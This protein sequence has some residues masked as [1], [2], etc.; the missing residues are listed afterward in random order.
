[1]NLIYLPLFLVLL[2]P[3][4]DVDARRVRELIDRL[5]SDRIEER[6][7]AAQDLQKIGKDAIP[8]LEAAIQDSKDPE[9]ALRLKAVL[10]SLAVPSAS[11]A[12]NR[13]ERTLSGA[14]AVRIAFHQETR[15][16]GR[17]LDL[18]Q[19]CAGTLLF[20]KGDKARLD[21]TP[22]KGPA[23]LMLSDGESLQRQSRPSIQSPKGLTGRLVSSVARVGIC[24]Y[25]PLSPWKMVNFPDEATPEP[26]LTV[27]DLALDGV[28]AETATL[29]YTLK[30]HDHHPGLKV[31]LA[32][33]PRTFKPQKRTMTLPHPEAT[34]TLVEVYDQVVL[35]PDLPGGT[36][37]F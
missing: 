31:R 26:T 3:P 25:G 21:L 34:I 17:D 29:T 9:V 13:I 5:R 19:N 22:E 7:S 33:D 24:F 14:D 35:N 11:E 12:L 15:T 37:K 16:L 23:F 36:F 30:T 1:M 2:L 4:Q 20:A 18:R 6:N 8:A 27:S 32:F 10:H 28:G